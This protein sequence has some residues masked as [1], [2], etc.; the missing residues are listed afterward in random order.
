MAVFIGVA[1]GCGADTTTNTTV[2]EATARVEESAY[3]EEVVG[4][5]DSALENDSKDS[6]QESDGESAVD[7]NMANRDYTDTSGEVMYE[8]TESDLIISNGNNE[9]YGRLYAPVTDTRSPAIILG[10]GYNGSYRDFTSACEY[11][12]KHG[13]IAYAYDF[14]GGSTRAKSTGA[15]KDMTITSEK[16]D[17]LAVFEA[18]ASRDD[19]A[20]DEVFVMGASH[21]GLATALAAEELGTRARGMILLYPAFCIPDD[22]RAYFPSGA[23]VPDTVDFWGMTLG[24]S[25]IEEITELDVFS[26]IGSYP[27]PV[28]IFHGNEDAIVPLSYS[29]KAA[30]LY[31]DASLVIMDGEG[32][33]FTSA[34]NTSA[35]E[36]AVE[37]MNGN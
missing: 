20:S 12:A 31:P 26:A 18:I 11:C 27:N 36:Q 16:E 1:S 22:W 4:D 8:I 25:Y 5:E 13:Y 6:A 15:T 30:S 23:V 9:I 17:C 19:V 34:G 32:H 28:I 7:K 21:G 2:E 24:R 3:E 10:H 29:E 35:I 37:F 33:G 14:C